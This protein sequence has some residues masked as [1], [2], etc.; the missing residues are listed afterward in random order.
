MEFMG[1]FLYLG[2]LFF[3]GVV[4]SDSWTGRLVK[5]LY[6]SM[7]ILGWKWLTEPS[8]LQL[9]GWNVSW[10]GF[11]S[12]LLLI[13][14][15]AFQFGVAWLRSQV[16]RLRIS[17]Q[18]EEDLANWMLRLRVFNDGPGIA[19]SPRAIVTGLFDAEHER[20]PLPT[21]PLEVHWT[22]DMTEIPPEDNRTIG[23]LSTRRE[24]LRSLHIA[25]KRHW[26][27]LDKYLDDYGNVTLEVIVQTDGKISQKET[28]YFLVERDNSEIGFRHRNAGDMTQ[29][30]SK[31]E[32]TERS[33]EQGYVSRKLTHFVG[34]AKSSDEECY[35]VLVKILTEGWLTHP[36]HR[37]VRDNSG[38]S[39][40]AQTGGLKI[41]LSGSLV[42]GTMYSHQVVCFCDIPVRNL[43]LH[44][45]KY[46][47]FG[48][49]FSKSFLVQRGAS[50][51]F[52]VAVDSNVRSKKVPTRQEDLYEYLTSS[53]YCSPRAEVL[54]ELIRDLNRML[55]SMAAPDSPESTEGRRLFG[56]LGHQV[57]SF[58]RG[59]DSRLSA[60]DSKNYYMERE[61]RV[62]GNVNFNL[63]DVSRIIIPKSYAERLRQDIPGYR[64]EL[65]I[66]EGL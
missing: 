32:S 1:R 47:S 10:G 37:L 36:P 39:I 12:L 3:T 63:D 2:R 9:F 66:V 51:V 21:L 53:K 49:A 25:G 6:F 55:L 56:L 60:D 23:L 26:L 13:A 45:K 41:D 27:P 58:I 5:L 31:S 20:I 34:S 42:K 15:L 17:K 38:R 16:P 61:W 43:P 57:L 46:G 59:F 44:M 48:L 65:T 22:H 8:G 62:V 18:M 11:T 64:G 24:G 4:W 33:K 30:D 50:P 28:S 7:L 52:Y 40:P 29:Q 35:S 19:A 54:D 14:F